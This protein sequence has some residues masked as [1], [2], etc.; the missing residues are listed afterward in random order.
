M[1][2][3]LRS[4]ITLLNRILSAV[5]RLAEWMQARPGLSVILSSWVFFTATAIR[6]Q[7]RLFWYDELLTVYISGLPRLSDLWQA[8]RAGLDLN[9]PLLHLSVRYAGQAFGSGPLV[10]RL[11]VLLA[12]LAMSLCLFFYLRRKVPAGWA[13]TAMMLPWLT[14]A[15]RFSMEARPYGILLGASGAAL[16]F[17]SRATDPKRPSWAPPCLALSLA[18]ALLTHC[19][20]VL[21]AI[22]LIA[23]EAVRL[24][25]SRRPDWTLWVW[26]AL[27]AFP[28]AMYPSLM[29]ANPAPPVQSSSPF[30]VTAWTIPETYRE[31]LDPAFWPLILVV[32][33]V[34]LA[35]KS[36]PA[37]KQ[38][39][40]PAH[41]LAALSAFTAIPVFAVMLGAV[42]TGT[43]SLRYGV[44]A[45]IGISCLLAWA[46]ARCSRVNSARSGA[47]VALVFFVLFTGGFAR[48]LWSAAHPPGV[49]AAEAPAAPASPRIDVPGYPLFSLASDSRLPV[50]IASGM[51]FLNVDYYGDDALRA[52]AYYLMDAQ[53]ALK[54]TGSA[55]F[56]T[57][58]PTVKRLLHVRA[59]I[60][61]ADTFLAREPRFL[62][63]CSGYVVEWLPQE[64]LARGWHL[65]L[66]GK[67]GPAEML[68][69]T[70]PA[71]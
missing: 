30:H 6:A 42:T 50:V 58:Y 36:S 24:R 60:E 11:P 48:Q 61:P 46:G 63:Y 43:Y 38:G 7:H 22:P 35:G 9:P 55:W 66:L 32:L 44:Q 49:R 8:L 67:D 3:L 21:L 69:V 33:A 56:D 64:L 59:N 47:A 65:R 54:R 27:A 5:D 20:A 14:E 51:I 31:L 16:Y 4:S 29:A 15:Y 52:R 1:L 41:E 71:P 68:D 37:Q 39:S 26:M 62:L 18:A 2:R 70:A 28:L 45:V 40:L 17:W 12:V 25:A 57:T 34:A 53:A 10:A 19:Y 13:L 23:G